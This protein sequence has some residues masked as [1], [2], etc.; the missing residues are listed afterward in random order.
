MNRTG[1]DRALHVIVSL[2]VGVVGLVDVG[3]EDSLKP[4]DR[5]VA[6]S[7]RH[8]HPHR[9]AVGLRKPLAIELVAGD[10]RQFPWSLFQH[11]ANR[12]RCL[13]HLLR[14]VVVAAVEENTAD[15]LLRLRKPEDLARGTPSQSPIP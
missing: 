7:P 3:E 15:V 14:V 6:V 13:K 10:D 4:L 11:P 12:Q 1:L 2:G 5:P 8:D 9:P